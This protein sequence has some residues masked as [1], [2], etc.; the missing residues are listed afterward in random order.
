VLLVNSLEFN[1]PTAREL[2][3]YLRF[4]EVLGKAGWYLI[5]V[6]VVGDVII[7]ITNRCRAIAP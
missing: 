3:P 5:C 4:G 6:V 1:S 2:S 7:W